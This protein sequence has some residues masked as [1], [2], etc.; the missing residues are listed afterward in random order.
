LSDPSTRAGRAWSAAG[1]FA[2]S[3]AISILLL[4]A[5]LRAYDA[6]LAA[7]AGGAVLPIL[8]PSPTGL[9]YG[10]RPNVNLSV[11]IGRR[12]V[13]I[14]TNSHGMRWREVDRAKGSRRRIAFQGDSFAFGCWSDSVEDSVVGV[15]ERGVS[16]T[17]WEVL[18]FGVGGY[19][20]PDEELQ[21]ER[22]VLGFS[23]D[24]VIV[25][26][27]AG[28]D[29]RDAHLGLDKSDL[30]DGVARLIDAKV[31]AR[32]PA[33][34][35]V[36]DPT[37]CPPSGVAPWRARL[38]RLVTFRRLAAL[39]GRENLSL[40]FAVNRNF[41]MFTYWSQHPYPPIALQARDEALACFGRMQETLRTHGAR[42]AIVAVPYREQVHSRV[43]A[44]RDFDVAFPQVY[45]QTFAREHGI[46]YLDLLPIFRA[47]VADHNRRL[48]LDGDIHLN[49]L[50]H[51]LAGEAIAEW[52]RACVKGG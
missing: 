17:L 14:Q 13:R 52:F 41:T 38:D 4:E 12:L 10:L 36:E 46:P 50:G 47:H 31:R 3:S 18:G 29:F 23:P 24:F 49:Q 11:P 19:G 20:P 30:G 42:L 22:Q 5:A 44:G 33:D 16:A 1:L 43:T 40:E 34:Q 35:L 27:F 6:H 48:Y 8:Q 51:R 7:P 32:V 39:L 28:N 9:G 37:S 2:V 45:V 21:L 15:F 25:V 26:F